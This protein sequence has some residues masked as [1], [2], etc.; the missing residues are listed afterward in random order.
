MGVLV[1]MVLPAQNLIKMAPQVIVVNLGPKNPH[2]DESIFPHLHF[3]YTPGIKAVLPDENAMNHS[4]EIQGKPGFLV[5]AVNEKQIN[6]FGFLLSILEGQFFDYN[7]KKALKAKY[8][9]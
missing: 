2:F 3:Y 4:F 9:K 1:M 8:K 5:T 7:P 6:E